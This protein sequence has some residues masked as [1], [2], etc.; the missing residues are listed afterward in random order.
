[1][2]L[3]EHAHEPVGAV[4]TVRGQ[5][6]RHVGG[7]MFVDAAGGELLAKRFDESDGEPLHRAVW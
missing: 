5:A 2:T 3:P 1:M 6:M 7:G 4:I